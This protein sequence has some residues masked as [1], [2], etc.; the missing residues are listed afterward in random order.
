M[1]RVLRCAILA[2]SLRASLADDDDDDDDA[3]KKQAPGLAIT[4]GGA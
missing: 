2:V 1:R 4:H 3:P